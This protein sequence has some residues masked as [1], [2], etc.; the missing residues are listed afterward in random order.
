MPKEAFH[1]SQKILN[2]LG[3]AL[4]FLELYLFQHTIF[5]IKWLLIF[6]F[7]EEFISFLVFGCDFENE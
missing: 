6:F 5:S 4:V 3:G 7:F 2:A 1:Y